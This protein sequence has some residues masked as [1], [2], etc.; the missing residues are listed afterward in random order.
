LCAFTASFAQKA[1][2]ENWAGACTIL[3]VNVIIGV[4]VWSAF[5]GDDEDEMTRRMAV[6]HKNKVR[7]TD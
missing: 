3:V 6:P 1:Q 4:Y 7:T 5:H 2:P